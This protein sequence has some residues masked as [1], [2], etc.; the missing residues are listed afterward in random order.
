MNKLLS[1][2]VL[3]LA[4][5][6]SSYAQF[7]ANG[8]VLDEGGEA[9]PGV[10][11]I[12]VGTPSGTVTDIDGKFKIEVPDGSEFVEFSFI[13][14]QSIKL[15]PAKDMQVIMGQSNESLKD[16]VVVGYAEQS[17]RY[18]IQ[19]TAQVSGE[20]LKQIQAVSP[21]QLLQGQAAGVQMTNSSGVLGS[22]SNIRVRGVASITG[23]SQPLYVIDGVP[24]N[25]GDYT[26]NLGG[27]SA[28]NPLM[29]INPN[30]IESM[31]VLKDASA[32]AIYGSRGSNG[33]ILITTK[34]GTKSE[35][36]AGNISFSYNNQFSTPTKL[37]DMMNADEF[38]TFRNAYLTANGG[39]AVDYGD[40]SF[41]WPTNVVRTGMLNN[42][43]L[44][45]SGGNE[46]GTFYL[47]GNYS[48]ESGFTIG[49]DLERYAG[50][51]NFDYK[52]TD[53]LK[54][55]ANIS[56]SNVVNDRIGAE[57]NTEAPLTTAYLQLPFVEPRDEN[58]NFVNTG[59]LQNVIG[60]EA[61][62]TAR[63]ENRRTIANT[64]AEVSILDNLKFKTDFGIDYVYA[65][66]KLRQV[67][68][69]SPG[70]YGYRRIIQDNKYLTT[71]TL[72]YNKTVG[73]SYFSVLAGYSY[74]TS[75][76]TTMAVEATGFA[77]D[78]LP[79][80]GSASTPSITSETV[81]QWALE[82][83]FARL[84]YRFK[85]RYI[86]EGTVRRDG[87]S[88][89]GPDSK[90][91][92]FYAASAGWII[93][94]EAFLSDVSWLDYMKL[95]ASYGTAGNDNIGNFSYLALYGTGVAADYAGSSGLIPTQ[96]PN[97]ALSWEETTQLDVG[98]ST[99]MFDQRL[100][101]D[102]NY[103]EKTTNGI[104]LDV[105]I[106]FTTGYASFSQN[107]GVLGN[108]GVDVQVSTVNV[109]NQD[110]NWTTSINLGFLENEVI[111]IPDDNQDRFGN[112][113]IAGSASQN[114][115]EGMSLNEFYLIRY[116][117]IN[118]E[119]GDAEWLDAD[120]NPTTTPTPDDRVYAGSAI[121]SV[122]GGFT[123][124]LRY[125]NFDLNMLINF[126]YG[127]K[128]MLDGLRFT[129]NYASGSF[130]K[131]R[132]LLDYWTE[133]NTDA[134]APALTSSTAATFNQRSTFQLMD[135]SYARLKNVTLGYNIPFKNTFIASAR[136]YAQAQ[137]IFTLV[138][139]DFRGQDPEI[140]AY[141]GNNLRQGESF[142]AIPQAKSYG[143]GVNL[144]F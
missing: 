135:G 136:I 31:T 96:T 41:D 87:S 131:S 68:L 50:R 26:N 43:V 1:S 52:V 91:G 132:D 33:V 128:V 64:F 63:F 65:D 37:L 114:T 124:N 14:Y 30:D 122:T 117:G 54:V 66:E 22:A 18:T 93:S 81:T 94:D 24:L 60:L 103:Y 35:G 69:F 70:G 83:Q 88:R 127:N 51:L 133:D 79:N 119:T 107:I 44:S 125:K 78:K 105:P 74:E 23:G 102:L 138:S 8:K 46:N 6:F 32:V 116:N 15:K 142:F 61:L 144:T 101:I 53:Y 80:V 40:G 109:R 84:N 16:I 115:V 104:L 95:S 55:G 100:S 5:S 106:P 86:L 27:G 120:G 45:T 126:S 2:L 4:C 73:E 42:Y 140:T 10:T 77:N 71:N 39:E 59:F 67:D 97:S 13:G 17:K 130:N 56:I 29:S 113:I 7:T 19:S 49:N 143:F 85:D 110:W 92:V 139:P 38:S 134:F 141:A 75:K 12:A 47:S 36:K 34:K 137:N 82:S 112:D 62:N 121:P 118:P 21:Q 108:R 89:F 11:V 90:Y 111:D 57:N 72:A 3:L 58:G 98:I 20:N 25:T 129:E 76:L 48:N 123:S 99:E 9:L 28:L